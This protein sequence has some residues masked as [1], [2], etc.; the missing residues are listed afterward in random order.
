MTIHIPFDSS[1]LDKIIKNPDQE[2]S[3]TLGSLKYS[4]KIIIPYYKK[5][6]DAYFKDLID[7]SLEYECAA[8]EI[9]FN[10]DHF[11]IAINFQS[12]VEVNLYDD[13]SKL[14]DGLCDI[15][16]RVGPIVLRNVY[17]SSAIRD[18]GHRNRFPQFQFHIDRSE[19]QITRY[20][21]YTRN[22][23][24]EE[25]KHPRTASTLFTPNIAAYLQ[26]VK[27]NQ[28][29]KNVDKG[30]P[31]SSLLF[32]KENLEDIM[33]KVILEQTWSEPE[34]T[35]EIAMIDNATVLHASYY[36]DAS[37]SG[38]RI[39]VRYLAGKNLV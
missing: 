9:P 2:F 18:Q 22:P 25:Q 1:W 38:Y 29:Q 3:G 11:G 33:G 32:E 35:G 12:P 28:L 5:N 34:G 26:A 6:I 36:R 17:F 20:S 4:A 30:A 14:H 8:A 37:Q 27:Q 21:L 7:T 23:F 15:M 31:T 13:E 16:A 19:V 39:G 24:D 10:F